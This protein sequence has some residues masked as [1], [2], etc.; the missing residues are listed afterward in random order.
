MKL[1]TCKSCGAEKPLASFYSRHSSCISC[2]R[3]RSKTHRNSL[4]P[5][6]TM[7]YPEMLAHRLPLGRVCEVYPNKETNE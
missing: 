7:S 4:S 5:D 1:R 3:E 2:H 6:D